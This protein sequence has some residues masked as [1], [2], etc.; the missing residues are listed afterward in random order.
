MT[1][2][3]ALQRNSGP[4]AEFY[5]CDFHVHSPAS[6]DIRNGERLGQLTERER[7]N[8]EQ[9]DLA[10]AGDPVRYEQAI[11]QAFPVSDYYN[12]LTERR[13]NVAD[14]QG[15]SSNERWAFVA[16]TDHNVCGYSAAL[17]AYAWDRVKN[18]NLVVLPG[19]ELDVQFPVPDGDSDAKAHIL[20]IFAPL[21]T[22]VDIRIAVHD[23][24]GINWEF[25]GGI[26][27]RS[28]PA[29][30]K[31]LR[32]HCDYPAICV[33]AHVGSS[34]G[35]QNE[36]KEAMLQTLSNVD[37][38]IARLEG[39]LAQRDRTEEYLNVY[40][41]LLED[42]RSKEDAISLEVLR[43]IGS[44]G[45]DALQVACKEDEV[46][47]RR[48]HRFNEDFGR[49]VP[50]VCSDAHRVGS[51][52]DCDGQVPFIKLAQRRIPKDLFEEVRERGLRYG[53]TRFAFTAPGSVGS[54]ISAIEIK[55]DAEDAARFWP[56]EEKV[57]TPGG[58]KSFVILLSRN[59]NCLIGGRGSGKSAFLQTIDFVQ[60]PK[61]FEFN[62]RKK[63]EERN[64]WYRIT[65]ATIN[66]CEVR[67]FWQ[68]QGLGNGN[69][70][71]RPVIASRYFGVSGKHSPVTYKDADG[72]E[73]SQAATPDCRV[74]LYRVHDIESAAAPDRLRNLFD[75]ICGKEIEEMESNIQ[76]AIKALEKNRGVLLQIAA[77]IHAL[78][79]DGVPLREYVRRKL[80]YAAV[81][82]PEVQRKYEEVDQASKAERVSKGTKTAWSDL[83]SAFDLE[84]RTAEI[85]A[86]EKSTI[87]SI[88]VEDTR[89][90]S[91][92]CDPLFG[93]IELTKNDSDRFDSGLI[94]R[95]L[96]AVSALKEVLQAGTGAL[97]TAA[98]EIAEK[99]RLAREVLQEAG[100]PPGSKERESKKIAF[101][102]AQEALNAY[103]R[104][105]EQ[106]NDQRRSRGQLFQE[107]KTH[108]QR[109]TELRK[110]TAERITSQLLKDL[111]P[112]VLRITLDAQPMADREDFRKWLRK[113][114]G[115]GMPPQ[116]KDNRLNALVAK[117]LQP[118]K[119]RD[120]LLGNLETVTDMTVDAKSADDG[121][122]TAADATKYIEAC[123]GRF[124]LDPEE[125]IASCDDPQKGDL[126]Q[127]VQKG[128]WMFPEAS[129][130]KRSLQVDAVLQLDE[131]LLD[132]LPE[133]LLN[134]RPN[135][136]GSRP[137]PLKELSP[138]QRCSA[139]LPILMLNGS[140]PI[141][142]D[143]PEDNLDNR[144]IRQ[145]I[146]NILASMKLRRQII[147]ATHN[148]NLPVLGDVEQ[149]IILRGIEEKACMLEATGQ[150][151]EA[152][153]VG[154][155][156][157]IMEGG[158]EA[159]QYRH[160]IYAS[161]WKGPVASNEEEAPPVMAVEQTP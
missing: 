78:T 145:V 67:I 113:Y 159:F 131:V 37:A 157:D 68:F 24:A 29:F 12:L 134:D 72:T 84:S 51:V 58:G 18:K 63:L 49:A 32:H 15:L 121:K 16:V 104:L 160:T 4:K 26:T 122:I 91:P 8:V 102:E 14:T 41:K 106:W 50:I 156:T 90:K 126:P 146:V 80:E 36:T 114:L 74:Q 23:A 44:C 13:D 79:A 34:K 60:R 99:H 147:I 25:G 10:F 1:E 86:F 69:T 123:R 54:W 65:H 115:K 100:L 82:K 153:V 128:L 154:H 152:D 112:S 21:T 73:L 61:E 144:L 92:H 64:D 85:L 130:G 56:F 9:V 94:K 2:K 150:L 11:L 22:A 89:D 33:A 101:D 110:T 46:H 43:L 151:D 57:G 30:T 136:N 129:E 42:K 141:I 76:A 45:F 127:E 3:T 107:L 95:V 17:S 132:D 38:E 27:V 161:H 149:A 5:L 35:V 81:N 40:K 28:L 142:I 59:L 111:D 137:R 93:A 103:Q 105:N 120:L 19:L 155:I 47:Y 138:G 117:G 71:I 119:L 98:A 135:E 55:P 125:A 70:S 66:G 148:A 116:Y 48:L 158:R 7:Q 143:Q 139:I 75:D 6:F 88:V 53:E 31:A 108:C 124:Q 20:C 52:F 133:I 77:E 118:E 97:N 140:C 62:D 109:R 96:A 87:E 83:V 39:E